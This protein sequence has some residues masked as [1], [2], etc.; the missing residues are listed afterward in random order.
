[1]SDKLHEGE[2]SEFYRIGSVNGYDNVRVCLLIIPK[3]STNCFRFIKCKLSF[4]RELQYRSSG[5]LTR[6]PVSN[7]EPLT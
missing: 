6:L 5:I 3:L 4:L 2:G 7:T 1:M